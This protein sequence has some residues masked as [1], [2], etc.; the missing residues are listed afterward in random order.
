MLIFDLEHLNDC[1]YGDHEFLQVNDELADASK[2]YSSTCRM[3]L[4]YTIP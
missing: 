1:T 3:S 2:V 4:H